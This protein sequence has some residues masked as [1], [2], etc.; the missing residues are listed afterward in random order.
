MRDEFEG[1]Y[2][3]LTTSYLGIPSSRWVTTRRPDSARVALARSASLVEAT[4]HKIIGELG[5]ETRIRSDAKH[6]LVVNMHQMVLLPILLEAAASYPRSSSEL[7]Q[8]TAYGRVRL[9]QHAALRA[10]VEHDFRLILS[11]AS[12]GHVGQISGHA[13]LQALGSVYDRLK[14]AASEAWG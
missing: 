2:K 3:D 5:L 11:A 6:F 4:L 9:G 7:L 10:D 1:V 12:A 14:T 8:S 13:V